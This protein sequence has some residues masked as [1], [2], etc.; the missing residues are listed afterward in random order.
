MVTCPNCSR[1]DEEH[2]FHFAMIAAAFANWPHD[3]RFQPMNPEHLRGWLYVEAGFANSA[4]II[5]PE[6]ITVDVVKA[7]RAIVNPFTYI[8]M[9]RIEDGLRITAPKSVKKKELGKKEFREVQDKVAA[10]ISSVIGVQVEDLVKGHR[11][12]A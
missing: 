8:R 4:D 9:T 5:G 10:I 11:R 3:H 2:N 6:A 1:S 7:T 12:A